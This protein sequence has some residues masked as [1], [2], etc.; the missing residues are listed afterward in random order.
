MG[1]EQETHG[2]ILLYFVFFSTS[3]SRL[4]SFCCN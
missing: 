4:Y 1:A 2:N 3:L